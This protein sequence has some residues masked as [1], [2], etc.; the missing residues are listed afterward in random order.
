MSSIGPHT[1]FMKPNQESQH[2]LRFLHSA[3]E[4]IHI[5]HIKDMNWMAQSIAKTRLYSIFNSFLLR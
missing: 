5:W 3:A 4:I 2:C 1:T